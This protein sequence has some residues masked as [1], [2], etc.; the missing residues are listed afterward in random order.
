MSSIPA[1]LA[2]PSS[3]TTERSYHFQG[4]VFRTHSDTEV[5]QPSAG[6]ATSEQRAHYALSPRGIHWDELDED[7]AVD[8][9]L[10]GQGDQRW[11]RLEAA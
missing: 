9:L 10:A 6:M 4:G 2:S 5:I 8:G 7:I 1:P 11:H 3:S